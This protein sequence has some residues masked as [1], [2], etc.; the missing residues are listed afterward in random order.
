MDNEHMLLELDHISKIYGDLHAVDD[1]SLTVPQGQWLAIVGSSGSGK[2]TL[3]NMIGCMDTPSKG[4]VMLEGRRLE[5]LNARQLADVRKNM[6][7]LVFQKFY[8]VPHLTAVENVMVAQYYH[9]VVDEKQA[10]EALERVG[11]K[12]RAHHLPSQLSGGEQ[13]RVCI[14]R[15]L[16]NCPKL[17]LADEP[18]GNLDEK[19]EKIVL[20]LFRQLHE[21]G[22]TIIVVTHDALVASC[23]QREIMLNHGVLVGEQ[24]NDEDAKRAYEAAGGKPAF[25][26]SAAEGAQNGGVAISFADPTKAAKTGDTDAA[27]VAVAAGVADDTDVE[28][29]VTKGEQA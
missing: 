9:S 26:G 23:A 3:M 25:T 1:L 27:N 8:L 14:A 28:P 13:Q 17:I 15:A 21:Q 5:D 19:N 2:T 4:S 18:T 11:L 7:G 29:D 6:I 24:W 22:T 20:D 10:M 16:I 12:D